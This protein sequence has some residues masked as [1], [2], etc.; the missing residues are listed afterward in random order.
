MRLSVRSR[1]LTGL[2]L[3][4]MSAAGALLFAWPFLGAGLPSATPA[5]AVAVGAA[6][7]LIAVE[8]GTRR[9]DSR[10][11][12]LLAALAALDA[13]L[14]LALV[15]GIGGFSPMFLL[16][17]CAG[18]VFGPAYGFLVGAAS[19]LLSAL[20]TGGVGPWLPYETFAAGWVGVAGGAVGLGRS[21]TPGRSDLVRLAVVGVAAG[22]VYGAV[23]DVWDWTFF[24]GATDFGWVPGLSPGDAAARFA[25]Y[26]MATSAVYDSFRA[27]GNVLMIV[28]VGLPVLHAMRR[29]RSRFEVEEVA[30]TD[31]LEGAA[32]LA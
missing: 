17:L 29:F 15:F 11:L 24:R 10:A 12:A 25:R 30:G 26:Y 28:V 2:W 3:T 16:I 19:M 5:M 4:A 31:T 14:R 23:M 32:G 7:T 8:T 20:A 6:F 1:V 9:L 18:Y 13:A 21:G 22:F 27:A